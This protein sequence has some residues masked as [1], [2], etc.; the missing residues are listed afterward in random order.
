[1]ITL[2]HLRPRRRFNWL[3]RTATRAARSPVRG[4]IDARTGE[5]V[6]FSGKGRRRREGAG[7]M[8]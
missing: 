3:L 5:V 2:R 8:R 6:F 1:M 7:A 4:V